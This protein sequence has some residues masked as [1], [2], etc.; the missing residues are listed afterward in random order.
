MQNFDFI[1]K[2]KKILTRGLSLFQSEEN[3]EIWNFQEMY[4][5][6]T[7]KKQYINM[8]LSVE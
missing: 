2:M 5:Y 1:L 8:V 3:D 7:S 4:I 6:G